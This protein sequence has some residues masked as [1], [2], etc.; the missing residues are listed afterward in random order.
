MDYK[1]VENCSQRRLITISLRPG[2]HWKQAAL[3]PDL[4]N[5]FSYDL[6]EEI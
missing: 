5:I 1:V 4:V 3:G 6:D 2:G